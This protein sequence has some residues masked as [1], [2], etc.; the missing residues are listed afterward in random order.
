MKTGLGE[1]EKLALIEFLIN[2]NGW[3]RTSKL[4][5]IKE[6]CEVEDSD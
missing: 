5:R 3:D 6:I 4:E 2:T 1:D